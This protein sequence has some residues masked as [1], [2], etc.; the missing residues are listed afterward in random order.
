MTTA[1]PGSSSQGA[2]EI[3]RGLEVVP[4]RPEH[5]VLLVEQGGDP[6]F[7]RVVSGDQAPGTM[8]T[9]TST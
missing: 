9:P 8:H 7:H 1:K 4:D 3:E 5:D 6:R 2:V